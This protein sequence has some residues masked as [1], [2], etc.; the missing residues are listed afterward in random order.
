M[1][2]EHSSRFQGRHEKYVEGCSEDS[3][4]LR[5]CSYPGQSCYLKPSRLQIHW[6]LPGSMPRRL[7]ILKPQSLVSKILNGS[8]LKDQD[9][10]DS[11]AFLTIGQSIIYN[12]KEKTSRIAVKTRHTLECE[13]SLPIYIGI[14][15]HALSR[16]KTLIQQLYQMGISISYDR[17]MDIEDWIAT[18]TTLYRR[19]STYSCMS[20]ERVVHC[21]RPGQPRPQPQLNHFPNFIPWDWNQPFSVAYQDQSWCEQTTYYDTILWK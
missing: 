7:N 10:R 6:L 16:S 17:I 9:K 3:R 21:W 15:V 11:R 20:P 4:L 19:W 13:P 12:T 1:M 2:E 5:R 18:S 14:N 8:N